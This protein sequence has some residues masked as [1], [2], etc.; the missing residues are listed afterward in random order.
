[1]H[2]RFDGRE[3]SGPDNG[4]CFRTE[5]AGTGLDR[6]EWAKK[7]VSLGAG[8]IVLNSI[9]ADGTKAG[10]RSGSSRGG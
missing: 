7:A 4:Q 9:D 1:M 2:R 6:I 8:E 3:K 10:F 5:A